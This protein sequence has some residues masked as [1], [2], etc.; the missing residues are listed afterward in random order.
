MALIGPHDKA[1]LASMGR[2][3]QAGEEGQGLVFFLGERAH[4]EYIVGTDDDA[5]FLALASARIDDGRYFSG[6]LGAVGFGCH[7]V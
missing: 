1:L 6:G 7:A 2:D 4:F 5:I 3:L